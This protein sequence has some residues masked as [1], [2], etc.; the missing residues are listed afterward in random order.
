MSWHTNAIVIKGDYS[1]DYPSLFEKLGL[2]GAN[3][4]GAVSFKEASSTFSEGVGA[5]TVEGWTGLWGNMALLMISNEAVGEATKDTVAFQ[6][7]LEGT[8]DTAG[9]TLWKNGKV[10]RQWM[11]QA[12]EMVKEEGDPLPEEKDAFADDDDEQAVLQLLER[13]TLPMEKFMN[14]PYQMYNFPEEALFGM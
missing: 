5:A 12:G 14:A 9:F 8:S 10:I 13:F 6:M 4:G 7:I 2:T 3:R 11:R 1:A